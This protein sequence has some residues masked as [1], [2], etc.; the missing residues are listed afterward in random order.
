MISQ[1][2]G[3]ENIK[4]VMANYVDISIGRNYVAMASVACVMKYVEFIQGVYIAE[5]T[6]QVVLSPS[7]RRLLM[8]Q[9]TISAV[10]LV[11]GTRGRKDG[12]SLCKMLNQT[13]TSA[14]NRLLRST[15][16]V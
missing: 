6:I 5:K 4:R 2:K 1:T 16:C 12:Q 15:V 8:D 3:A 7:T 11:Q 13:Q 9:A 10:E 14:G